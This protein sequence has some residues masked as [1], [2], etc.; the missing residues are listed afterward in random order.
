MKSL[1][2]ISI[3]QLSVWQDLDA[4]DELDDVPI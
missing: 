1:R 4:A 3:G 2:P